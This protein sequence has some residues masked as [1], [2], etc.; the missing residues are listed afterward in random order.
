M[1]G[2]AVKRVCVEALTHRY[3]LVGDLHRRL[4]YTSAREYIHQCEQIFEDARDFQ[5]RKYEFEPKLLT[6]AQFRQIA[7]FAKKHGLK[8]R[9]YHGIR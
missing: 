6:P 7:H 2:P 4:E 9:I 5:R 8:V 3:R 1:S